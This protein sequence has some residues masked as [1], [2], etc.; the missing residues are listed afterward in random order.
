MGILSLILRSLKHYKLSNLATAAGVAI[1][2]SVICGALIVGDS[3]NYS[4]F[5]ILDY[6]LGKTT[7]SITAGERIFTQNIAKKLDLNPEI[8]AS[9]ILFTNGNISQ[10]GTG[11][12]VNNI[13]IYGLQ[14]SFGYFYNCNDNLFDISHGEA[15]LSKNLADKLSISVGDFILVRL[16]NIGTIP[17]N[18]PFVSQEN[19]IISRR[20]KIAGIV[21]KNKAANFNLNASQISPYNLF[22]NIDWLNRVL[23][24][25]NSANII[26]TELENTIP[27]ETL[28]DEL[29]NYISIHD[30][31]IQISLCETTNNYLL[32]SERVFIDSYLSGQINSL[33][34]E[35]QL[36]F[37]YFVNRF[38]HNNQSTPYSFICAADSKKIKLNKNEIIINQWLADDLQIS[39][40]DTLFIEYFQ[41]GLLREMYENKHLFIVSGI[42]SME[43][44]YAHKNLMPNIPGLS[45]AGNCRDWNTGVPIDLQSIRQKDEEYWETYKGT[46]K[47]FISLETGQDLWENRF[48][49][50]TTIAIPSDIYSK[51]EINKIIQENI[52]LSRLEF[53]INELRKYGELAAKN[54]E[55]FSSL[56][57][58][59]GMFIIFSGLLL[60]VL[61]LNLNLKRRESQIKLYYSSGFSQKLIRKI[62]LGEFFVIATI[63]ALIGV[64]ISLFYSKLIMIGL[65][66]VWNDIVRTDILDLHFSYSSIIVGFISGGVLSIIVGYFGIKSNIYKLNPAK[67]HINIKPLSKNKLFKKIAIIPVLLSFSLFIFLII[68][69]HFD[70][71]FIWFIAGLAFLVSVLTIVIAH[72]Y[73]D[74]LVPDT[75]TSVLRLSLRNLKRN[76]SRSLIIIVLLSLGSFI[77]LTTAANRKEISMDYSD[78]QSGTGGFLFFAETSIPIFRN[79][80]EK[81]AKSELSIPDNLEFVQF[82]S[83]YEDDASCLNLNQVANPRIL[84]ANPKKLENRFSFVNFYDN[85]NSKSPWMQ[86]NDNLNGLIPAIADQTVIRWGLGKSVGDTLFYQNSAGEE[87]KLILIAGLANSIFQGNVIISE[88]N[89]KKHF[90]KMSGT[91]VFLIDSE[92]KNTTQVEEDLSLIFRDYGW[93]MTPTNIKLTEFNSV[94]NTYLQIFILLGALGVLLGISGLAIVLIKSLIERKSEL[95]LFSSMGF[96]I[97]IISSIYITE[98]IILLI[99]G[100]LIGSFSAIIAGFP[101]FSEDFS[102]SIIQIININLILI[103]NGIF[104]IILITALLSRK[105]S[106]PIALKNE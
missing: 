91:N 23:E 28:N 74:N 14:N 88:E 18:T 17:S 77:I 12:A 16:R 6:R 66:Q 87:I 80:N 20:I 94:E 51:K 8:K 106:I 57:A 29:H 5:Q 10:Q 53:R 64:I 84:A 35:A 93:E 26:I 72:I 102:S 90:P 40:G 76:P 45:D 85:A 7:H 13:S 104:W 34:P 44:S 48:G 32:T 105:I 79:L 4:L 101:A 62:I 86:L 71:I 33:V 97:K 96:S 9:P 92:N 83:V 2:T 65:N 56:F 42:I 78:Y 67:K 63:G 60:T 19:Q 27:I 58:G 24:L 99:A 59:L 38:V 1:T 54:G 98:Y 25:E 46:P 95:A 70:E 39:I 47:A 36:F 81:D 68:F 22:V 30:L 15:L 61:M 37:S 69:K 55:D 50:L 41:I 43:D 21:D 3:I 89:F 75:K 100:I 73:S 49:N 11:L 103:I 52:D 82:L 31:N